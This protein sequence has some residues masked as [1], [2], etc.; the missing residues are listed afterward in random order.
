MPSACRHPHA[1]L[2]LRQP[3]LCPSEC[4]ECATLIAP[5]NHW[6]GYCPGVADLASSLC[7]LPPAL[8]PE[9]PSLEALL[10]EYWRLMP[11][12]QGVKLDDL[13]VRVGY[14]IPLLV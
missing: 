11:Q 4:A 12:Y 14:H 10:E 3:D 1:C 8:Q 2:A 7:L 9:R 6:P 13:Q 5:A